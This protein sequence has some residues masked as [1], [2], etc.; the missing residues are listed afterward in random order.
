MLQKQSKKEEK[1]RAREEKK[2]R[3]VKKPKVDRDVQ[4]AKK[5]EKGRLITRLWNLHSETVILATEEGGTAT[6][7]CLET[8][9]TK[10][11][12]N[13]D[14]T[15]A[16]IEA[17]PR[18]SAGASTTTPR[19]TSGSAATEDDFSKLLKTCNLA[20]QE[21]LASK[22]KS[23]GSDTLATTEVLTKLYQQKADLET[24]S[25]IPSEVKQRMISSLDK[26]TQEQLSKL[27]F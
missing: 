20:V 5:D 21:K 1:L 13:Y 27:T 3:Q 17:S 19:T 18:K 14:N 23:L 15:E 10:F 22:E 26:G 8:L 2:E 25:V 4:K 6:A 12:E 7:T 9:R 11:E 24:N 16:F